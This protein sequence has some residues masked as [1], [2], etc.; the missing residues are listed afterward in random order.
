MLFQIVVAR[1]NEDISYL[2]PF[3]KV[4]I[5][6]NKGNNNIPEEFTN[7]IHLP[8]IGRESHTYLYHIINN[9]N[10]LAD[11]T[12][13]IQ[14]NIK[15]HKLLDF[16]E[17]IQNNDFTGKLSENNIIILKSS[18]NH[19]GKYLK[20][21]K[22][23]ILKKSNYTP[24]NFMNNI[25]GLDLRNENKINIVWGAN[26]SVLNHL[27]INRPIEYYK[28]I[29]KYVEYDNNP[30]EGHFFERSWYLIFKHPKFNHKKTILYYYLNNNSYLNNSN[31][32]DNNNYLNDNIHEIH[33][34]FSSSNFIPTNYKPI[35]KYINNLQYIQIYPYIKDNSF[36]IKI[37]NN[38]YLLFEFYYDKYEVFFENNN[39]HIYHYGIDKNII[40]A[41]YKKKL[42]NNPIKFTW[43]ND[44][45][46]ID[47][48]LE[49][50]IKLLDNL[51]LNKLMIRGENSFIDYTLNDIDSYANNST[52]YNKKILFFYTQ[53]N[54]IDNDFY[55][56]NYHDYYNI[57]LDYIK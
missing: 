20:D 52:L 19:K 42:K 46:T 49:F 14:G 43:T 41:K 24:F 35:I 3:A 30:E 8:N 12:I 25:L 15:D 17:Y 13:F 33:Y 38:I 51:S 2:I 48:I 37:T 55:L 39:V 4:C 26:F 56:H 18:I 47:N 21:L 16:K 23:G 40:S 22:K 54:N 57:K 11:N 7:I 27:I 32:I 34:W 44:T 10:N 29:I 28:N 1:Y 45:F 50:P 9:Y 6:Y 5:I 53:N 31:Y 36:E